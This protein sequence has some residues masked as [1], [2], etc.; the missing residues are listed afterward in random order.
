M[1]QVR[2]KIKSFDSFYIFLALNYLSSIASF[3]NASFQGK[4]CLPRKKKLFTVLKSPH[5][6]K[7]AREQFQY[8]RFK[9]NLV[10]GFDHSWKALLFIQLIK[11]CEITGTEIELEMSSNDFFLEIK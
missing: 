3:V 8:N 4:I 10:L 7:S 6:Y 1:I 11:D 2:C 9:Q 5:K